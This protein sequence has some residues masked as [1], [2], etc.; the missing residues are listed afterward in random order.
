MSQEKS[1]FFDLFFEL[2]PG[3]NADR[4]ID[5]KLQSFAI[6]ICLYFVEQ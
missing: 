6:D 5:A 4:M 1:A 2:F 3:V